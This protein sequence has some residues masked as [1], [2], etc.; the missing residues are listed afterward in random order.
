MTSFHGR[1]SFEITDKGSNQ[2][3]NENGEFLEKTDLITFF[4]IGRSVLDRNLTNVFHQSGL[5]DNDNKELHGFSMRI[6]IWESNST[7]LFVSA[8]L[9]RGMLH[10]NLDAVNNEATIFI[11]SLLLPHSLRLAGTVFPLDDNI[12]SGMKKR[13]F[14]KSIS[15]QWIHD[16][17]IHRFDNYILRLG[18]AV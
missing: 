9:R 15:S 14:L 10:L 16:R 5:P 6:D 1:K 12:L 18:L 11:Q 3:E 13:R 2:I 17:I 7:D 8:K 4:A